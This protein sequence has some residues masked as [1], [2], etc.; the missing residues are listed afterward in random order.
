LDKRYDRALARK[1][2]FILLSH[3]SCSIVKWLLTAYKNIGRDQLL[4]FK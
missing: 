1:A 4:F 2:F 3:I